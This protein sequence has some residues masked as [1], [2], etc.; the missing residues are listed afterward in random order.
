MKNHSKKKSL[1]NRLDHRA[2]EPSRSH[3]HIDVEDTVGTRLLITLVLNFIIPVVQV[4][5]GLLANSMALI[6]DAVHNFSDFTAIL[7]SY[8]AFKIG[9][10][11]ASVKNTFG[12]R[13]AEIMAALL[14]VMILTGASLFIIYGAVHRIHH[15]EV[16]SGLVVV[17]AAGIGILGNGF[18]AWLLHRDSKHSL[19]VRSAF[20]HMLG[21]FLF[22]IAVLLNGLVLIFKPW[23]WL[24]PLLSILIV[25]FI[26]KSCWS[27]LKE[28]TAVLMNAAPKGFD[29]KEIKDY[30]ELIP[31]VLRVH[32]LHV[33]NVSSSSIAFSCHVVVPDQLVSHAKK[34][35]EV[36]HEKLLHRFGIDHPVLQFET[37]ECG[38]GS[39]LCGISCKGNHSVD[40]LPLAKKGKRLRKKKINLLR[41]L[42]HTARWILGVVFISA[43][44]D[45]IIHPS[46]F[47]EAIYNYQ[48][49]PDVFI[50][51]TAI[52]LP[53]LELILGIMLIIGVWMPGAVVISNLLL[54]TFMGALLFNM[55]RGLDI[56]CGCFSISATQSSIN[57]WIVLRDASFLILSVYLLFVVFFK[58]PSAASKEINHKPS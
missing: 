58:K 1:H 50:N 27:I 37:N 18:S 26:L 57:I 39:L 23:Y 41:I 19:N 20:L 44:F 2:G 48:I 15:P 6:S 14:N 25:L 56:Y 32:Y 38:N 8:V 43:S 21:D 35:S 33:W 3:H 11:G 7:I 13:R 4:I 46:A 47:S 51:P 12:Y 49:L 40:S 29:L 17:L 54:T 36:I 31:G 34:L 22:S 45:K 52:V 24:D 55:A 30:L 9:R 16:V 53:W 42:Y 28:S 10:K 5:G